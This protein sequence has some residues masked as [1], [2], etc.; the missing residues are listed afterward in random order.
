M[1]QPLPSYFLCFSKFF[2]FTEISADLIHETHSIST[3]GQTGET[4]PVSLQ[5]G[6]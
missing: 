5:S 3:L 2:L 6:I 1:L 4:E